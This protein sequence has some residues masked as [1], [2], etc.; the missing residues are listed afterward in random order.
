DTTTGFGPEMINMIGGYTNGTYWV[1]VVNYSQ[2]YPAGASGD[3]KQ[4]Q[5]WDVADVQLRVY[6]AEGLAFQM[7]AAQPATAPTALSPATPVAGCGAGGASDWQQCEL[8]QAFK[9]TISGS[10][11]AG[12]VYTPVN[13]YVNWQDATGTY[14]NNK[15]NLNGF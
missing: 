11:P 15:C 6:D 12:R 2:W 5:Q 1:T 10:G 7:Q 4:N 14:D 9:F 13:T 3:T 8:W